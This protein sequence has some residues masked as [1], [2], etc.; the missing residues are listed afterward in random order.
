MPK[1]TMNLRVDSKLKKDAEKVIDELGISMSAAI[2]IY[3]KMI[4]RN[5]GIPFDL[6]ITKE[7]PKKKTTVSKPVEDD[8]DFNDLDFDTSDS[9][10]R[11][12]DK[13]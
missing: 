9:I 11:A 8:D 1:T 10:R 13:L 5:K 12:I 7:D 4:V 3:L 6:R 2:N